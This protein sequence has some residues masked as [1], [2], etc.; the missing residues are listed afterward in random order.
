MQT[1]IFFGVTRFSVYAPG[2]QAWKLSKDEVSEQA[3]IQN[4]YSDERLSTRFDIFLN[5][6]LPI[7]QKMSEKHNYRHIVQFSELM[8]EKWKN[9]LLKSA[10]DFPVVLLQKVAN[11]TASIDAM[12][13]ELRRQQCDSSSVVWFRVDDDDILS[14]DYL[15]QLERYAIPEFSGMAVCFGSGI[16]AAYSEGRFH[17]FRLIRKH[18]MALGLAYVGRYDA[19]TE[20]LVF[21]KASDHTKTDI[22]TPVIIDSR[23]PA[24]LWAHH[25]SQDTCVDIEKQAATNKIDSLLAALPRITQPDNFG[26]VFPTVVDDIRKDASL[27]ED[28]F[29][30]DCEIKPGQTPIH[31]SCSIPHGWINFEFSIH[32]EGKGS[33]NDA[34]II[35]E[36]D[37][38]PPFGEIP[39]LT[40]STND[41]IGWY[42]YLP[43]TKG[44]SSGGFDIKLPS[45][46]KCTGFRIQAWSCL[47]NSVTLTKLKIQKM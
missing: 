31:F 30:L 6:A 14:S 3:Y 44:I 9:K 10:E 36:F 11:S 41:R 2:N 33:Y 13:G 24:Y 4:L 22:H 17:N 16:T 38:Q 28:I 39:G 12:L 40:K 42:R 23:R 25:D 1:K 27:G 7:Y 35:F 46:V 29:E 19:A 5:R 21:P 18:F 26:T 15:D 45:G 37:G 8:P 32:A 43:T 20:K 47:A 34:I